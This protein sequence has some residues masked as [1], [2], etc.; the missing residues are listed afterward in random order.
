M[1]SG[2]SSL[3]TSTAGQQIRPRWVSLSGAP[4]NETLVTLVHT[5]LKDYSLSAFKKSVVIARTVQNTEKF[6]FFNKFFTH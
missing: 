4:H 1:L 6:F 2:C 5:P 3:I